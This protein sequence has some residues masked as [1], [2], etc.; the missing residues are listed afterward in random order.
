MEKIFI[1]GGSGTVGMSFIEQYY[2]KYKFFSY[3]RNEKMQVSLKRNFPNIEIILG[4]VEDK[5]ALH[6]SI[7]KIKPD[8]IIHAAAL[9]HV[10]SAETSP[11]AAIKSNILGSLNVIEAAVDNSVPVTV[12][13]ST[14]KACS[15]DS[16]YGYTK[17]LMEKM[18]L[19]SHTTKTKFSVC[20]FGNV[21]HSHG[22]VI[23]FWLGLKAD[24]KSLPLTHKAMNR[25]M[26]SRDEAARLVYSAVLKS[27]DESESFIL[28]RKMKTVNMFKLA[29]IIS[30]NIEHVGLRPGEKLNETLINEKEVSRTFLEGE[31]ITIREYDNLGNNKLDDEYSSENAEFMS[32]KEMVAMLMEADANLDK[33]LL[34]SRIY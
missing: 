34:E 5:L 10:D 32:E 12:A 2:E 26:F 8:I 7:A 22:S 30:Q 3:S 23:P 27:Q 31:F 13:I 9:K 25:L 15:A 14:D 20:R 29:Q 18:F 24:K 1:T 21:S 17:A 28:S 33:S 16:N 4:S 6:T 11:I 19:E